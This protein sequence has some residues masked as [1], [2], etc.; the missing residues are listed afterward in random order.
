MNR[1]AEFC[2]PQTQALI[3]LNPCTTDHVA[4]ILADY[5]GS[6]YQPDTDQFLYEGILFDYFTAGVRVD[7]GDNGEIDRRYGYILVEPRSK[8]LISFLGD[9]VGDCEKL[10]HELNTEDSTN[11]PGLFKRFI[12]WLDKKANPHEYQNYTEN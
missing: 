12:T 6:E 8:K 4:A 11:Q 5:P 3:N 2:T 7:F 10:K 9:A 1:D